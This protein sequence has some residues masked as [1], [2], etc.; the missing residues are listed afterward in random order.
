[1]NSFIYIIIKMEIRAY[2]R[3]LLSAVPARN[4]L[5][6]FCSTFLDY[7]TI[8]SS[9]YLEG[10]YIQIALN[11]LKYVLFYSYHKH[12][13]FLKYVLDITLLEASTT[14]SAIFSV[15]TLE[16]I[17]QADRAQKRANCAFF[18]NSMIFR[19]VLI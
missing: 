17:V 5:F 3:Q 18:V 10:F 8:K 9:L 12:Y 19:L 6:Q 7:K 13:A 4:A 16:D 2:F 11:L 1:M 14:I 15:G